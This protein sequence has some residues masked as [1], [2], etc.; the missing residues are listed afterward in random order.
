MCYF[1]DLP[2]RAKW[3]KG[4]QL[5]IPQGLFGSPWKVLYLWVLLHFLD[6]RLE[7]K[8]RNLDKPFTVDWKIGTF[9]SLIFF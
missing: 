2:K 8:T 9:F 1:L 4:C 7:L 5:T 3:F 6:D